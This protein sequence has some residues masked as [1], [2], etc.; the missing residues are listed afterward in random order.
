MSLEKRELQVFWNWYVLLFALIL[1]QF[2]SSSHL[3]LLKS[4]WSQ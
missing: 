1:Q 3:K 4:S 2:L